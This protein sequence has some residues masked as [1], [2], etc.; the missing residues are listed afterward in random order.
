MVG[1]LFPY[2]VCT[3]KQLQVVKEQVKAG[4]E[5]DKAEKT[6]QGLL[7]DSIYRKEN[8]IWLLLCDVLIKQY[9]LG[10]ENYI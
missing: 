8:R 9:E 2:V 6:L 5:L 1:F 7:D 10:N 3:E 4:K